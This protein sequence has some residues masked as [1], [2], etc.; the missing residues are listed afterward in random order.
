MSQI[1]ND[2]EFRQALSDLDEAQQRTVAAMFVEHVLALS[3]DDR[4][5]RAVKVATD[6]SA[7]EGEISDALKSA[8]SAIMDC[9]TRCGAEGNWTDQAG[10][11]VARAAVAA[12][13]PARQSKSGGPAWQAA[14]SSRMAQTSILIDND[15]GEIPEHSENK[16]QYGILSDYLKS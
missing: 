15:S 14:M 9:S 13:T 11:F 1:N 6:N 5:R 8:K 7:S 4:V 16:W 3:D 10:Y 12:V 2:T